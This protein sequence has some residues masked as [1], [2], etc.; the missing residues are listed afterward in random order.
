MKE[1]KVGQTVYDYGFGEG[2]VFNIGYD[3]TY[4]VIAQFGDRQRTY[5][6][7]G[8]YIKGDKRQMLSHHPHRESQ[9]RVI[10]VFD[11]FNKKGWVNRVMIKQ[12]DGSAVCWDSAESIEEA[13]NITYTTKWNKWR[14]V[15]DTVELTVQDIS[16]G[17][18]VGVDPK[19]IKIKE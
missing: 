11:T 14:E 8:Y 6:K 7:E 16:D 2:V 5:T 18:G 10:E 9:E 17:K 3:H 12:I 1:F 15:Q 19:L 13:E 4:P